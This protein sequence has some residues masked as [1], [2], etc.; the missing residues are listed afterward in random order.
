MTDKIVILS[1]CASEEEAAKLARA[2]VNARLAACVNV[3][4]AVRSF[5]RWKGR[6]E[7]S[8]ECLL[9][10]KSSLPVFAEVRAE[11]EKWH[12]YE[13]PE[14]IALPILQG[15]PSYLSW[16]EENLGAE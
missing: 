5:Y 12:S 8:A 6:V 16:L 7:D 15:S 4:P 2:L 3:L 14:I 9:I 10:I 13:V 11:L 1:T